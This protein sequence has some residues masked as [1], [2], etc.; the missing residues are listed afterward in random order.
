MNYTRY[1]A[2]FTLSDDISV[3]EQ[4]TRV[5]EII[6]DEYEPL[7]IERCVK[8]RY[9]FLEKYEQQKVTDL[10]KSLAREGADE[11]VPDYTHRKQ[12]VISALEKYFEEYDTVVPGG[13]VDF[14]M[15]D[16][17]YYAQTLADI[18]ADMFFDEREYEEF[19]YLLSMF[20]QGKESCEEVIHLLWQEDDIR[21]INKHGRDVTDKYEKEFRLA[22]EGKDIGKED[23]AISAVISAA[24]EKLIFHSPPESSPLKQTLAKIFAGRCK[25]CAGCSLCKNS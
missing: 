1:S 8:S 2:S 13:F 4:A 15:R 14:R 23:L 11:Q 5:A 25:V 24:P 19:T 20:V 9:S 10:A 6:M 7:L 22:A 12:A 18:G 16:I 17:Y 21:L 3:K